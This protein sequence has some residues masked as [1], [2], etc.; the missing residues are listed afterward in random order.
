MSGPGGWSGHEPVIVTVTPNPS[1][2]RTLEVERVERGAVIRASSTRIDAGGK[3]VN[4]TR[5]LVA[6]GFASVAV[7][8]LGGGDGDVL[9]R[10]LVDGGIPHR[11][12]PTSA[13]TRSNITLS[14]PDGTV[15]KVNA[16][17]APLDRAEMVALVD[18]AVANLG[19]ASWLVLCGSLPAG[20]PVD[21]YATLTIRA[22][23]AGVR[24]AV[25]SSGAPLAASIAAGPDLIK[26][27]LA[28]LA[29]LVD[30][31]LDGI[32]DAVAAAEEVRAAGVGTVVVSLGARGALLVDGG[33]P[34]LAV[35]P[36]V[37]A[38]SDVGAGD[39]LLAGFL[40]AGGAGAA[41][42][43]TG[44]AWAAAAVALPGT[45][46]PGPADIHLA[47]VTLGP[48]VPQRPAVPP[49]PAAPLRPA[50]SNP[51]HPVPATGPQTPIGEPMTFAVDDLVTTDLVALDL[52]TTDRRSTIEALADL[53]V[54]AGRLT[55]RTGF[56]EA[57]WARE[58]E[59]G[60]TGMESGIAI[61]HAKH[62]GVTQPSVVVA[63][64]PGGVDFGAEDAPADLVFLIAAPAGADDVHITVLSKLA[65]RLVHESFRNA[66]RQAP[67]AEAVVLILKEQIQ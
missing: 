67:N 54:A 58:Q 33:D 4:V 29:E 14:E 10:L 65:R 39:T 40:A 53:L 46:M 5:A 26:P 35:P 49:D 57:V 9:S 28:E 61:P 51:P 17:G 25:D 43:R 37:A 41:A 42:L 16:P 55:D 64:V 62:A 38:R 2:D 52:A 24:V 30:R 13:G 34:V 66:L 21:L 44:V 60:G 63:T 11:P 1:V 19:A 31:P 47:D 15:T 48:A 8:P 27:N 12:V 56:V 45:E 7:L 6:N 50:L 23:A 36:A 20:A 22:R 59:T 32:D 3:G 18:E